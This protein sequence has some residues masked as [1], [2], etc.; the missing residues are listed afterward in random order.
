MSTKPPESHDDEMQ[1]EFDE[2]HRSH[3][4]VF[5]LYCARTIEFIKIGINGRSVSK[6]PP[7]FPLDEIR[8]TTRHGDTGKNRFRINS[9]HGR[10]YADMFKA[11]HPEFAFIFDSRERT[12][13]KRPPVNRPPLGPEHY[14]AKQ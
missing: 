4:A 1:A 6:L 2:F 13:K 8:A 11:R 3:P 9:N 10:F 14:K 12:S 7:K 5:E